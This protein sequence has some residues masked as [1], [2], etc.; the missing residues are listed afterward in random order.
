[1]QLLDP[2]HTG[3]HAAA[4]PGMMEVKGTGSLSLPSWLGTFSLSGRTLVGGQGPHLISTCPPSHPVPPALTTGH[5]TFN[6]VRP[7]LEHL[8]SICSP[9]RTPPHP[10]RPNSNGPFSL[11][12]SPISRAPSLSGA[13]VAPASLVNWSVETPVI[14]P[15]SSRSGRN[16][17]RRGPR[18]SCMGWSRAERTCGVPPLL[19][20]RSPE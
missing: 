15:P 5:S 17:P 8:S 3:P 12:V 14:F 1:M 20:C 13:P 10:L 18:L 11:R 2:S 7:L 9:W 4:K 6:P 16:S 19:T